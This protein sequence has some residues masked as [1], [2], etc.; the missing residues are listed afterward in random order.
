MGTSTRQ[1]TVGE[2]TKRSTPSM[3]TP[4]AR[5][6]DRR[7]IHSRRWTSWGTRMFLTQA[8]VLAASFA[9][10][11]LVAIVVGPPLFH[12][13][14]LQ[15]GRQIDP[16]VLPHI[17]RAFTDAGVASLAAGLVVALVLALFASWYETNRFRQP[18]EQLTFAAS[19]VSAGDYSARVPKVGFSSELDGV[20][21]AFN[22]MAHR[23]D[24]TEETRRR[25]L[26]DVAHEVRTPIATLTA[27]LEA[28]ADDITP[29]NDETQHLLLLQ[30][31]RLQRIARDLDTVS[32]A[33]EDRLTL[34]REPVATNDL[35]DL[36]VSTARGR[37]LAKG[38]SLE[39]QS[40]RVPLEVDPQRIG[41][42]LGNLLENALRHTPP[43]GTVHIEGGRVGD[44]AIITVSDTGDGLTPGQLD[45]VFERFYRADVARTRDAAGAGIGLTI[46]RGLAIAHGG[47]LTATS[48]GEKMGATFTLSL[49]AE[50][51]TS[52]APRGSTNTQQ[53]SSTDAAVPPN[54]V[55]LSHPHGADT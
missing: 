43:G 38:V 13:H 18:M 50:V 31:E 15:I 24:A 10:A 45:H 55:S 16:A 12:E 51:T 19:Q 30:A 17:E 4:D 29:W 14:L 53:Q 27:L 28:V 9:T 39:H 3:A 33:E 34:V 1:R 37:Y 8:I 7:S 41:Q 21:T 35:V 23:L 5:G 25:L 49:P 32:R 47:S 6:R 22:D 40:E 20:G 11:G 46:S 36:A 2:P 44:S 52:S 48:P 42:I 54:S 26:S